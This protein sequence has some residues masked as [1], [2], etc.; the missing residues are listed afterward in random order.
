MDLRREAW[1]RG[2]M[3]PGEACSETEDLGTCCETLG[4]R[5]VHPSMREV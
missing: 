5:G 3:R 4:E 2:L 1:L